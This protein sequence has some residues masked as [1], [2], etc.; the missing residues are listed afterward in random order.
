MKPKVL[1]VLPA[2]SLL[3][4]CIASFRLY[5]IKGPLS[6]Q[7]PLPVF[8]GKVTG[9]LNSG[10]MASVWDLV[11]G[12]GYFIAHVLGARLYAQAAITGSRG[13]ALNVEFYRPNPGGEQIRIFGVAKDSK[14]GVYK[15]VFNT[16]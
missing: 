16:M 3:A 14:D 6:A 7:T 4:G 9:V 15:M 2:L 13:T 11:Y 5:P 1:L 12:P 10:D 8:S